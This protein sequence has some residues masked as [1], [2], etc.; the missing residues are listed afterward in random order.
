MSSIQRMGKG[1][2]ALFGSA[3]NTQENI[4]AQPTSLSLDSMAPNPDQ[5][6]KHFSTESLEELRDSIKQQGIIQPILVRQKPNSTQYEI[7]AGERRWRAAA[8]AGLSEV[9]VFIRQLSDTEVMAAALIENIQREDLS[10]I[11]EAQAMFKL[12]EQFGI[13]QEELATRLGKSRSAIANS[14]RLLQLNTAAQEDLQFGRINAGHARALLSLIDTPETQEAL[15]LA[16]LEQGL[17]VRETEAA[18]QFYKEKGTFPWETCQHS[19]PMPIAAKSKPSNRTKSAYVKDLQEKVQDH[20]SIK[21]NI[22]G[23]NERGR[24]TFTY[25]NYDELCYLLE[26]LGINSHEEV[27]EPHDSEL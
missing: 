24:I 2:D 25:T 23:N 18:V 10:P 26:N 16:I 1:L 27:P 4:H 21:T 9:P 20:L 6:R 11:E 12:R 13:T 3:E 22:T 14:L 5:P 19:D 7:V 17:T 8:M 15:R